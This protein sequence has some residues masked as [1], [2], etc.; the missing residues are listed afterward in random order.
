MWHLGLLYKLDQLRFPRI[1]G[2]WVKD[3]LSNRSFSVKVNGT[4]SSSRPIDTSV[5]QGSVLGPI[6]FNIFYNSIIEDIIKVNTGLFADDLTIY[7]T[8]NKISVINS[9]LQAALGDIQD[10]LRRWRMKLSPSKTVCTLFSRSRTN[11]K[12]NLKLNKFHNNSKILME[13]Y[14]KFLGITLDPQLTFNKHVTNVKNRCSRR[15]TMLKSIRGRNWGASEKLLLTTYKVLIRSLIDY[16]HVITPTMTKDNYMILEGTQ[17]KAA[18]VITYWPPFTNTST[19]YS[20]LKLE[21]V[22]DRSID[23][24]IKF[25]YKGQR[26]NCNILELV[27]NHAKVLSAGFFG[28]GIIRNSILGSINSAK[29]PHTVSS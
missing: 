28:K 11:K 21:S 27:N 9:R 23:L 3:Y 13:K 5:P 19:I 25:L 18:R 14:P 7:S 20:T 26:Y 15:I 24:T 1:L 2:L 17:R 8:H 22:M 16:A 4:I 29:R 12:L 6:L 10:W